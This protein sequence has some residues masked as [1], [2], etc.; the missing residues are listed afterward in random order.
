MSRPQPAVLAALTPV[1]EVLEHLGVRHHVGGSLASSAYGFPRAT[2]DVDL[3]A[4]LVSEQVDAFVARLQ[5]DFY[6]E[7]TTVS[8]A[9]ERR[10]PFNLIHLDTMVKVDIFLPDARPFD[11][12]ELHRAGRSDWTWRK[13]RDRFR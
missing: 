6:V 10:Q 7:P 12:Q 1:V 9:V 8:Q 3:M 5:D 13:I 4:E 2:A 11:Q